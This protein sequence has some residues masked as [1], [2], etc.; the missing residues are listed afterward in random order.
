MKY[1]VLLFDA[2]DTLF[3]YDKAEYS[4]LEMTFKDFDLDYD[5]NFHL[6][7]YKIVN[8]KIWTEL[9]NNLITPDEL[10][11]ERFRRFFD[12]S[13]IQN[14]EPIKFANNYLVNLSKGYY[15]LPF[16]IETLNDLYKDF[17]MAIITNGL[18]EVQ[19]PRFLESGISE[20]FSQIIIS[21]EIGIAKPDKKIFEY[22]LNKMNHEDKSSVL[23]IG[24]KLKSDIIGGIN[25]GIDTCW[26]NLNGIP[27]VSTITPTYEINSLTELKEIVSN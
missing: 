27:N 22:A 26:V 10:K 15:L 6:K 7:K 8:R 9:E 5:S 3:D 17:N 25:Y 1:K 21:D 24:D 2:D 4:A 11:V 19:L 16:A 18:K 20:Y 13:S 14:I 23:M 12:S